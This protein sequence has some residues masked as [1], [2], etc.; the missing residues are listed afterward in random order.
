[1]KEVELD[2]RNR[3]MFKAVMLLDLKTEVGAKEC[4][5]DNREK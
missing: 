5:L 3:K 4:G 1:M 2:F